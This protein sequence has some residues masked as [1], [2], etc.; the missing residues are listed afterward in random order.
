MDMRWDL[1]VLYNSFNDK[2]FINDTD[3]F[4]YLINELNDW[5]DK[6]DKDSNKQEV[7]ETYIKYTLQLEDL[8]E[9]LYR[10]TSLSIAVDSSNDD[11]KKHM[12]IL[13]GKM[14]GLVLPEV[15][16]RK[17]LKDIDIKL[18]FESQLI[19]DHQFYLEEMK[20]NAGYLLSDK[21]EQLI[22]DMRMTGSNSWS[23]LQNMLVSE[24]SGIVDGEEV[25]VSDLK[26]KY[27]ENDSNVR[28]TAYDE[29]M[30]IYPKIAKISAAALNSIKGEVITISKKRGYPSPMHM[31]LQ[32][33]RMNEKTLNA[34]IE[35]I[36][37]KLPVFEKYFIKKAK[38]LGHDNGLPFY[39]IFAP[40]SDTE[41]KFSYDE[42]R[43]FIVSN[44][45]TF[46]DELADFAD[47]AFE[48]KWI[49]AE[50]RKGKRG[51]AF[52]AG[53]HSKRQCR[54]LTNF[55]GTFSSVTTLAHEL[56]HG[57][58]GYCLYDESSINCSYPM[59]IAETASIFC[60]SIVVNAAIEK[61]SDTQKLNILETQISDAGQV[62]V[63]IYGRFIFESEF[64]KMRE[65]APLSLDE[66]KSLFSHSQIKAYGSG[67]DKKYLHPYRWIDKPHYY[68]AGLNFYNFP[69]AF[70]LLFAKGLYAIYKKK[71]NAFVPEYFDILKN[72]GKHYIEDIT[73]MAGIDISKPD[74]WIQSL[75][76]IQQEIETFIKL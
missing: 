40:I 48:E 44:F 42:A 70:G 28:K 63:D 43:E 49:D 25:T 69:Y 9:T 59:P 60:E 55:A 23:M 51:G 58:H 74:F 65:N 19:R 41:M 14:N 72:S 11:A 71:G 46:S 4:Q 6:I 50:P 24:L 76:L 35:A 57:F 73:A 64:F 32:N 38:M 34:M 62:I 29:E 31:T 61:A 5:I 8:I 7:I 26:N 52:C 66:I 13:R 10:F 1:S 3:H 16:F 47:R 12:D 37:D 22:S 18:L 17:W 20:K 54:V 67:L 33:S 21:E 68:Y 36:E 56:G 39:D 75:S 53:I 30:S 15:K 27:Y 45:R 2:K